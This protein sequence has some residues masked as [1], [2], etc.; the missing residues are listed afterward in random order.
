MDSLHQRRWSPNDLHHLLS[1][2]RQ[3]DERLKQSYLPEIGNGYLEK[4]PLTQEQD[5][6]FDPQVDPQARCISNTTN[7][8]LPQ[9]NAWDVPDIFKGQPDESL[10]GPFLS[11]VFEN[12]PPG[13]R[14]VQIWYPQM[15]PQCAQALF[16]IRAQC[17]LTN[18]STHKS[19]GE[20][21]KT[22]NQAMMIRGIPS[23]LS[24]EDMMDILDNAGFQGHY[25]LFYMPMDQASLGYAFVS[26]LEANCARKFRSMFNGK[27]LSPTTPEKVCT[28]S[29]I[30]GIDKFKKLFRPRIR[31]IEPSQQKTSHG[32]SHRGRR[33]S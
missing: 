4:Q 5:F 29:P 8:V 14:D 6:T 16:D 25:N 24:R 33:R 23:N 31:P 19:D 17:R 32:T 3:N 11:N 22:S 2:V 20:I 12:P 27:R 28:I 9:F 13:L 1:I 30:S 15:Q 21:Q 18:V 26:F 7:W 10:T